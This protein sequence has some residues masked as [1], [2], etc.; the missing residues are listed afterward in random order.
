MRS[1]LS[2][3]A[4]IAV[5]IL[6]FFFLEMINLSL[7]PIPTDLDM[8]N[9]LAVDEYIHSLPYSAFVMIVFAYALGTF[10][11]SFIAGMVA[12][13]NRFWFGVIAGAAMLAYAAYK[14]FNVTHPAL[15]SSLI[16]SLSLLAGLLGARL[17]ASRN[18][19]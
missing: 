2:I 17:G 13:R 11:A 19:S 5:G 8:N 6:A 18:V 9:K 10:L 3:I 7:Y 16:L 15:I 1:I 14:V 4:G 12:R